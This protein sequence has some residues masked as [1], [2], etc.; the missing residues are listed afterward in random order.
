MAGKGRS[1]ASFSVDRKI[2]GKYPGYTYT[3]IRVLPKGINSQKEQARR[4]NKTLIYDWQTK[5]AT[6]I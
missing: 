4:K 5:T 3:N 2:E 6:V 1:S